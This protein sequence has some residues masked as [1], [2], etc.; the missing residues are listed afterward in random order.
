[1][2]AH[3]RRR[4]GCPPP[5][6]RVLAQGTTL[7]SR[8]PQECSSWTQYSTFTSPQQGEFRRRKDSREATPR[9][10]S[11]RTSLKLASSYSSKETHRH[12]GNRKEIP[13]INVFPSPP[14]FSEDV[15]HAKRHKES[16]MSLLREI[17][18]NLHN[19]TENVFPGYIAPY[20]S[21]DGGRNTH[22]SEAA[23]HHQ[24][25]SSESVF[26]LRKEFR[27]PGRSARELSSTTRRK[28]L[29]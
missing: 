28:R 21:R 17:M 2:L 18:K 24:A 27:Y 10:S 9:G 4:R 1:M 23:L 19:R 26:T 16:G 29:S 11:L 15:L 14:T 22:L 6:A 7:Y 20:R 8:T 5:K 3:L 25:W 12:D 13:P